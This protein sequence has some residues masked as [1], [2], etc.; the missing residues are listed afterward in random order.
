MISAVLQDRSAGVCELCGSDKNLKA[1]V[2]PPKKDESPES[3]VVICGT[4]ATAIEQSNWIQNIEHWRSLS[5]SIWNSEPSVQVLSHYILHKIKG[6]SWAQDALDAAY[7]DEDAAGWLEA[8]QSLDP[9]NIVHKD[10]NGNILLAGDTVTL[11]KDLDV[12]GAN[13]IAKRGTA[14]RNIRLVLDNAEQIEG[15]VNEQHIVILTQYVK[16]G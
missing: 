8:W 4:C 3:C 13:F 15:K 1:Y 10:S 16:K 5:N 9:S 7:L 6:Q 2:V 14:V 11:I 12:K